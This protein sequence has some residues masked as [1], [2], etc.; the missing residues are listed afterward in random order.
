MLHGRGLL[1]Q[2]IGDLRLFEQRFGG[3]KLLLFKCWQYSVFKTVDGLESYLLS[4]KSCPR[5][6]CDKRLTKSE[7]QQRQGNML[8]TQCESSL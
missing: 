7:K 6:M 2:G 5:Q 3:R 8:A 4:N 1:S